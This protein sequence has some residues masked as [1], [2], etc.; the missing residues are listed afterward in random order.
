MI[1]DGLV[2]GP[3]RK[4]VSALRGLMPLAEQGSIVQNPSGVVSLPYRAGSRS[5][6]GVEV[7]VLLCMHPLSFS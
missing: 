1:Y 3:K 4:K 2:N 7:P 5:W 6:N